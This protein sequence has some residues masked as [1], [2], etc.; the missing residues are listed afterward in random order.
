M[1]SLG[2]P[3]RRRVVLGHTLNTQ[4]LTKTKKSPNVLSKFTIWCWATFKSSWAACSP[5]AMGWTPLHESNRHIQSI[6]FNGS[7]LHKVCAEG[8]QP[9]KVKNRHLLKKTQDTR[10]IVQR[11]MTPQSP[12]KQAPWDLTQ[13]SQSPSAA[14]SYFPESHHGLKSLLFQ[15]LF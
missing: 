11:T 1:A 4:T 5:Q 10:N 2:H 7:R 13:F 6:P 14:L 15:R 8:V 9:C 12:S 3:G